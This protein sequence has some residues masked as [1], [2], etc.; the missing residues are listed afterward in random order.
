MINEIEEIAKEI[1]M[2]RNNLFGLNGIIDHIRMTHEGI[3]NNTN[4][5]NKQL[6]KLDDYSKELDRLLTEILEGMHLNSK[7]TQEKIELMISSRLEHLSENV[8]TSLSESEIH[9]I[10]IL[11]SIK[12]N[13]NKNL[14]FQND[15]KQKI[16]SFM[17]E[18][19]IFFTQTTEKFNKLHSRFNLLILLSG[20]IL[21]I[22]IIA[23]LR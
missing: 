6:A 17:S 23:I 19:N 18:S 13:Q 22:S 8:K 11:N 4:I 12:D 21:I 7:N 20:M 2:F 15:I 14:E 9:Q 16:H 3:K 10:Q 5:S 1:D